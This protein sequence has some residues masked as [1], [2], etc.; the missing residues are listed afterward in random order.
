MNHIYRINVF[1][2]HPRY[3]RSSISSSLHFLWFPLSLS[4]SPSFNFTTST[5]F[6]FHPHLTLHSP[7]S[8]PAQSQSAH[9]L[10][11]S[12]FDRH[13]V[14]RSLSLSLFLFFTTLHQPPAPF[15]PFPR[16]RMQGEHSRAC[17]VLVR[18]TGNRRGHVLA[19]VS[20]LIPSR[21]PATSLPPSSEVSVNFAEPQE[22]NKG[23]LVKTN[24]LLVGIQIDH[25]PFQRLLVS[26]LRFHLVAC[27]LRL[28]AAC[29]YVR[30]LIL[31]FSFVLRVSNQESDLSFIFH[32]R[33]FQSEEFSQK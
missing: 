4:L 27:P 23:T 26:F 3:P 15:S 29:T 7:L 19:R 30:I 28:F 9:F 16:A 11:S 31:F 2:T 12:H 6:P 20:S 17:Q 1:T 24:L 25:S 32:Y 22:R 33:L 18:P 5:V 14:A 13:Y 8:P 10:S 21:P